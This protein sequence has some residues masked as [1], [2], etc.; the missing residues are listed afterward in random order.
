M[1]R[2]ATELSNATPKAAWGGSCEADDSICQVF[3]TSQYLEACAA[4]G[5]STSMVRSNNKSQPPAILG[6]HILFR[7]YWVLCFDSGVGIG[8]WMSLSW[9][10]YEQIPG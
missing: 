1:Y 7:T 2:T 9:K 3:I 4:R 10:G 5:I 8:P 6:G